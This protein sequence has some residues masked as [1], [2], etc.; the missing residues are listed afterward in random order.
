MRW[1][2]FIHLYGLNL[3]FQRVGQGPPILLLA[4][5]TSLWREGLP[6][7]YTFFLGGDIGLAGNALAAQ[8][9]LGYRF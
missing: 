3:V 6:E 2:G 7:G 1:W 5:E 4:E 8:L 9:K